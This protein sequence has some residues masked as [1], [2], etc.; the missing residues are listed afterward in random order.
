MTLGNKRAAL[1]AWITAFAALGATAPV[2]A[3][4]YSGNDSD[5]IRQTVARLSFVSGDVSFA[6]GDAPD[7]WQLA[8]P[9]VPMTLGDRAWTAAGRLELQVHGGQV[10]R[11]GS[12]TDLTVLNL[13]EE[14][15]Q[16]SLSAGTGSFEI[17]RLGADEVFEV[18]TP[19]AAITFERPGNYRIDV[20]ANGDSRLQVRHGRALVASAGGQV[21][22]GAGEEIRIEGIEA[23]RYDIVAIARPDDWDRWVEQREARYANA[24]SYQYVSRDIAGA[25]DLDQYGR[26]QQVPSY[27][28][29]WTPLSAPSGGRRT[30]WAAGSGR[31]PGAGPGFPRSRGD[32]P[33][34]TMAG[35][36]F[37]ARDGTGCPWH[38]AWPSSP[39]VRRSSPSSAEAPAF[40]PRSA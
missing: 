34:I 35:G 11:L 12:D 39:T 13:T 4:P 17:P 26:W 23:P 21:P 16:L 40:R 10:V 15:K 25:D 9:N 2:S 38:P 30:A 6:R 27:G 36:S 7:E 33:P 5:E 22:L 24:R 14:T 37:G 32:G 29:C 18:D 19:N 1:V 20:N 28:W 8:D 3:Q 31:T